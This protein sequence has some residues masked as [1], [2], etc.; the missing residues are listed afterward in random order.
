MSHL[1]HHHRARVVSGLA[2]LALCATAA[3]SAQPAD[4]QPIKSSPTAAAAVHYVA[5]GDSYAA[6]EGLGLYE[7]G[8]DS[9]TNHC[10]RS[11][12]S[13]PQILAASR[14]P[15]FK[16]LKSAA[17][18]GAAT[19]DLFMASTVNADEPAQLDQLT[20]E[21]TMVSVT[22]G[23]NDAGFAKVLA[24][25][26]YSPAPA[27]QARLD[28]Q[29]GC[30]AALDP[31]VSKNIAALTGRPGSPKVTGISSIRSV[32]Q[33]I[34]HKAPKAQILISGYPKLFGSKSTDANGCLVSANLPIYLRSSDTQ[35]I[36]AKSADL[37]AGIK[38]AV[39]KSRK[40]GIDVH[41]VNA[42]K[43]FVGHNLCDSSA[44]WINSIILSG[45]PSLISPASFHPTFRGQIATSVGFAETGW[46][47]RH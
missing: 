43:Q 23:G 37:N 47:Y 38:Y 14:L 1:R 40:H 35:W 19:A 32:L 41:Y 21:T 13:Y 8:T 4:A 18:S 28:G 2:G 11:G 9:A 3:L 39:R 31:A 15:M 5:L 33:A 44:P 46:R 6:G 7:D 36:R 42:A 12:L 25:C 16:D 27:T 10:H 20:A 29:P 34:H 24:A 26:V 22:I 17:C 45:G 30:H